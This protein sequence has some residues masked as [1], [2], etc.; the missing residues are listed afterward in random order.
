M[1][2][3]R[4]RTYCLQLKA[5]WETQSSD[6]LLH[7]NKTSST[8]ETALMLSEN[9]LQ[10]ITKTKDKTQETI[11]NLDTGTITINKQAMSTDYSEEFLLKIEGILTQLS[12]KDTQVYEK[13]PLT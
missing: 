13:K 11:L 4:I 8:P 6:I 2:P 10:I 5:Y 1:T 3:E 9:E 7:K 12:T